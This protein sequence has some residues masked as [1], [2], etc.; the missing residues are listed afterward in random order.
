MSLT[1]AAPA[2]LNLAL[3]VTGRRA[4]GYHTL[5]S[6]MQTIDWYDTITI[7][8]SADGQW[9][10]TCD[11][12]LP[13]DD[14][15]IATRAAKLFCERAG[16]PCAYTVS[17]HKEVPVEAGMGGGSSDA[18]ALLRALSVV[19]RHPFTSEDKLSMAAQ[20]GADVPFFLAGGTLLAEG[21][22]TELSLL[23]SLP[24]CTFVVVKPDGGVSTPEAYRR[25]DSIP[26]LYHPDIDGMIAALQQQDL[27]GVAAHI[28]NSFEAPLELP[29]TATLT[30]FLR[31]HG[32]LAAAL[33]G[34]G[35]AVFG[36]FETSPAAEAAAKAVRTAFCPA[37]SADATDTL[38]VTDCFLR[39]E[40]VRVAHPLARFQRV[41]STVL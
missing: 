40:N 17:I 38:P 1:F 39:P 34:S 35:S 6:V 13:Q 21:I 33:T 22:G 24:N 5:R 30:A 23:P 32:A 18:A 29:H 19:I 27:H 8:A 16:V 7:A 9:H 41:S 20:L 2:K 31:E 11:G 36:V 25:L 12:G 15:N 10:L 14:N 28:G 3:D 4:D 37:E 26:T